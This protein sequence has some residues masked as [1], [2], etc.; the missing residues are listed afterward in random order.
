M[1]VKSNVAI[2][3]ASFCLII[4]TV[5]CGGYTATQPTTPAS[6]FQQINLVSD[7]TGN[8]AHKDS[9]LLNPWGIA[10]A[11]N[12][13]FWIAANNAGR[14]KIFDPA[15]VAQIPDAVDIL[16]PGNQPSTP[17]GVVFNPVAEDFK[18]SDTPAQFLF[19]TEDG[20]VSTWSEINGNLPSFA[21]MAVNDSGAGPVYKG[22]AILNPECCREFLALADF[23]D[24][25]IKTYSIRF[26]LLA[27]PGN[28]T[29]PD[30]PAGYA[31]FNIQLI[32][33]KVFITYAIQDDAKHD[34][35]RG[36]GNGIVNIFDQEGNFV[37]RLASNGPLNAPWGISKASANF[38]PFSN[39][40]LIGNFGDGTINAFDE[41]TG[42]FL[43]SLKDRTGNVISNP[44][45]WALIFRNDG[46]SDPNTL[47]I[48]AGSTNENHGLFA[49]ISFHN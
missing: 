39:A 25:S 13:P 36:A 9:G 46:M 37:R 4:V 34:P 24:G 29:D 14:A 44:G 45:L 20:T 18:V 48:T 49:T 40:I 47:Y 19:A 11:P 28:F 8:A 27:T 12:Q 23:H 26:E 41:T 42:N 2:A 15:G 32:G 31:P 43:G 21:I 3:L 7:T 22:L 1:K 6:G 10:F 17:T 38:G 30:L 35:V 16:T 33:D 5:G